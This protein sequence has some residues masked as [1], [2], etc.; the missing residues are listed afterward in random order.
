L[1]T[2]TIVP[3]GASAVSVETTAVSRAGGDV[4]G[5]D[6]GTG[7]EPEP[8]EDPFHM[9][10]AESAKALACPDARVTVVGPYYN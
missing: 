10:L 6:L 4:P 5:I 8:R 3:A 9:G 1:W 7:P 2:L